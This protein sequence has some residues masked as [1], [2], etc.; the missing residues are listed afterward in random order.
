MILD[1]LT[2]NNSVPKFPALRKKFP[3]KSRNREI[4]FPVLNRAHGPSDGWRT[5]LDA[6][7]MGMGRDSNRKNT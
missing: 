1:T 6:G 5:A 3:D 2:V 4:K 7:F